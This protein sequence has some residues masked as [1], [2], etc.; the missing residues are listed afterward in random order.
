MVSSSTLVYFVKQLLF[1]GLKYRYQQ[2]ILVVLLL[3][4][5]LH[6]ELML[7]LVLLLVHPLLVELTHYLQAWL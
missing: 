2:Y 5:V 4:E 6:L 1:V 7:G 3:L